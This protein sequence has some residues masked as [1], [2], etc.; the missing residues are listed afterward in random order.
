MLEWEKNYIYSITKLASV[1]KQWYNNHSDINLVNAPCTGTC[2][3]V[4]FGTMLLT[5]L[6]TTLS[7]VH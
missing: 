7:A 3:L 5:D 6:A 4:S 2:S 1:Q